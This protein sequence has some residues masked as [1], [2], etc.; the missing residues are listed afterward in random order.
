VL[1]HLLLALAAVIVVGRLLAPLFRA[2]GQPPV[3]GEVIAGIMLGPSLLGR[4]APA[5]YQYIFPDDVAPYLGTVAQLG[6]ISY[7]FMVGAELNP[8][9]VRRRLRA[10]MAPALAGVALP[11]ALGFGIAFYFHPRFA[12]DG[13]SA[14]HFALFMG[15]AMAIT[16]FPVLARILSDIGMTRSDLG[17]RALTCA[18]ISDIAGWSLLAL[19]IGVVHMTSGSALVVIAFVAGVVI[20]HDSRFAAALER[21]VRPFVTGVLLPAFFAF[22]GIRTEINLVSGTD[23]FVVILVIGVATA[24]KFGGTLIGARLAGL[25][26]RRSAALGILMNTRGLMELIV[27]N[28]GLDLGVISP[29]LFTMMVLMA[30]ATTMATTPVLGQVLRPAK[31]MP[32]RV[33]TDAAAGR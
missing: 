33:L 20:P 30:L 23:W 4:L 27:L 5:A 31:A 26:W 10:T 6:V 1:F 2:I 29:T 14:M 28:I 17:V 24:G 9:D 11:Y 19:V 32:R 3:I 22:T 12:P 15:V 25:D 16:A 18:A 7:M 13:V 21:R 8:D